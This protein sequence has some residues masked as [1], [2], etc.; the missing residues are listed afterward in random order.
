MK[1]PKTASKS[2][3]WKVISIIGNH[4]KKLIVLTGLCSILYWSQKT[5]ALKKLFIKLLALIEKQYA[6]KMEKTRKER[7]EMDKKVEQFTDFITLFK[8]K[9][10][11]SI[12]A[13]LTKFL[14]HSLDIEELEIKI[15][16][17]DLTIKEKKQTWEKYHE[18]IIK[19]ALAVLMSKGFLKL[20]NYIKEML[21]LIS[22]EDFTD[23]KKPSRTN[24]LG[25]VFIESF[26]GGIIV[27]SMKEILKLS[28]DCFSYFEKKLSKKVKITDIMEMFESALKF[29]RQSF[30]PKEKLEHKNTVISLGADL[31]TP[32]INSLNLKLIHKSKSPRKFK[33]KN[34]LNRLR[35]Q[36][37]QKSKTPIES[38]ITLINY[39][40]TLRYK[41]YR[42]YT[43]NGTL[44]AGLIFAL[45]RCG[46]NQIS[47]IHEIDKHAEDNSGYLI[48]GTKSNLVYEMSGE[49]KCDQ[50]NEEEIKTLSL[51]VNKFSQQFLDLITGVNFQ[52]I[53][54]AMIR[55]EFKKMNNR[56]K[57]LAFKRGTKEEKV[58]NTIKLIKQIIQEEFV[59][60]DC[61]KNDDLL[62]ETRTRE[63]FNVIRFPEDQIEF[64]VEMIDTNI[65]IAE[66]L[67]LQK[68]IENAVK[69]Y[70]ARIYY[71]KQFSKYFGIKE[72]EIN[73]E[74]NPQNAMPKDD[75]SNIM[76]LLERLS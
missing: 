74:N 64:D 59:D 67:K 21:I 16:K 56:L 72:D 69:E 25:R 19:M 5:G 48:D 71:G 54:D 37:V 8:S 53:Y 57:V 26:V 62:Y 41:N 29:L 66:E 60:K 11:D 22:E 17:K 33:L 31:F 10:K 51:R 9:S 76:E 73:I 12:Y 68:M 55:I 23:L 1:E 58:I 27:S 34:L 47:I 40:A 15:K 3:L 18:N 4:K 75:M 52:I 43:E 65:G 46:S 35:T 42:L 30:N 13:E 2:I 63:L 14:H 70:G 32:K 50:K 7:L 39:A 38:N 45:K 36:I 28:A 24:S 49:P 6:V 44:S 20:I 61:A